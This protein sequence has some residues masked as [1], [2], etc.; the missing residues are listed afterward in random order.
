MNIGRNALCPCGSGFKYKKCCISAPPEVTA[1][2]LLS[3]R[4]ADVVALMPVRDTR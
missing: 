3:L 2:Q 1:T 4:E